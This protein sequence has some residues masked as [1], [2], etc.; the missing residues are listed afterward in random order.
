M[1]LPPEI[2][3]RIRQA[4]QERPRG[5]EDG[6]RVDVD[7]YEK[8]WHAT[9]RFESSEARRNLLELRSAA[10]PRDGTSSARPCRW[11]NLFTTKMKS[12]RVRAFH[13]CRSRTTDARAVSLVDGR[14]MSKSEETL[15]PPR[16]R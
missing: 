3:S 7:E 9:L 14:K 4:E 15:H 11:S 13:K 12:R 2:L 8:D 5:M 1:V 10:S 6:A 16:P